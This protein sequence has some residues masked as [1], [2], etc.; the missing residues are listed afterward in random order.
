MFSAMTNKNQ[1][2]VQRMASAIMLR[3]LMGICAVLGSAGALAHGDSHHGLE[4]EWYMNIESEADLEANAGHSAENHSETH[5][6]HASSSRGYSDGDAHHSEASHGEASQGSNAA[7]HAVE[8]QPASGHHHQ[9][10]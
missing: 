2:Y 7:H 9:S 6:E 1:F 5:G 8:N 3:L 4:D 10:E